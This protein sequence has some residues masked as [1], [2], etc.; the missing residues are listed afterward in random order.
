VRQALAKKLADENKDAKAKVAALEKEKESLT[1]EAARIQALVQKLSK[2]VERE[3]QAAAAAAAAADRSKETATE[4][5]RQ[6]ALCTAQVSGLRV[7]ACLSK[8]VCM[9]VAPCAHERST[10]A[11]GWERGIWALTL[12]LCVCVRARV[13]FAWAATACV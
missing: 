11:R 6:L 7:S 1:A 13:S 4:L 2:D 12:C 10:S 5:Q 8:H 9:C 3:R